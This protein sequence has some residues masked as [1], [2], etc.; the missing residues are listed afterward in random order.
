M[1]FFFNT[2][3]DLVLLKK[4]VLLKLKT[5]TSQFKDFFHHSQRSYKRNNPTKMNLD[6]YTLDILFFILC[7][8]TLLKNNYNEYKDIMVKVLRSNYSTLSHPFEYK[9]IHSILDAM[10][11]EFQ[12][13]K[14]FICFHNKMKRHVGGM[15]KTHQFKEVMD[16]YR[17]YLT[18]RYY[19][20]KNLGQVFTPFVLID[21]ILDQIPCE[22]MSDPNSTFF[23][24]SAGMGGFLVVLYKRLMSSLAH[25]IKDKDQRHNHIISN[26]LFASEITE[27]NVA[28][29]KKIFGNQLHI[30]HGDTL[31]INTKKEFGI[32]KFR[33]IVGN[34]PFEKPQ[35]TET[36]KVAG[37]SLWDD[38]VRKSLN[39]WLLP[40]GYFGML[41]PPG[42]RKPSDKK[43]TTRGLW[44]LM[45]MKTTP[46]WIEMYNDKETKYYFEGNVA[47]RMDLVLLKNEKNN[48]KNYTVIKATDGNISK[49]YLFNF[50][51]LPNA[52]L[53]EWKKILT[54]DRTQGVNVLYS[55][56]YH[57][58]TRDLKE[59]Q[60]LH[61]KFPVIHSILK[62]N[63]KKL[64]YTNKKSKAGGFGVSKVIFN[65]FGG[66]NKPILDWKGQFG[67]T[68]HAFALPISSKKE[69]ETIL[70]YFNQNKL[71]VFANDFNWSTS[72]PTVSWKLFRHVKK[73]F[74]NF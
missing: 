13:N 18:P 45:T 25:V 41:L 35:K 47:I 39:E 53:K 32:D 26:M 29:M 69:G 1:D 71:D 38:F 36:R 66:W 8:R 63:K 40:D 58:Q 16:L 42:W 55:T 21:R 59:E 15:L 23:D 73:N 10:E 46:L 60:D 24:P 4:D 49:Q 12:T 28:M 19:E 51:F 7:S 30:F 9:D 3:E 70:N 11:Q 54:K 6:H 64:R 43:S 56:I 50:A 72:R 33:V 48:K 67:M 31:T 20:K 68:Q 52:H 37:D 14:L 34:P 5:M 74:Y 57:T 61:Y 65:E 2:N 27:N 17:R 44:E 22:V 62:Q